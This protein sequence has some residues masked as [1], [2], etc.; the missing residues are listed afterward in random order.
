MAKLFIGCDYINFSYA[1][2]NYHGVVSKIILAEKTI[3][4]VDYH[5]IE[6]HHSG[7]FEASCTRNE[8]TDQL[9][10]TEHLSSSP[11]LTSILLT[12]LAGNT[13]ILQLEG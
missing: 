11:E 2:A 4:R 13:R 12:A 8:E 5:S 7:R 6:D 10:W 3:Y 9:H 1:E